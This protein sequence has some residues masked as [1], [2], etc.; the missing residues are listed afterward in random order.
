MILHSPLEG[1]SPEVRAC[2]RRAVRHHIRA[3]MPVAEA[4]VLTRYG[5]FEVHDPD[6]DRDQLQRLAWQ[7]QEF[8]PRA[9]LEPANDPASLF[10]DVTGCDAHFGGIEPLC[11]QVAEHF[12]QQGYRVRIAVA[13]TF[14]AAWGLAHHQ[15]SPDQ[16]GRRSRQTFI[17][18]ATTENLQ[19]RLAPLPVPAL[20]L[21]GEMIALLDECGLRSIGQ[22]LKL[23]RKSL[24]SRFGPELL[25][26][27]DQALG[28][29]EELLEP[30]I[31]PVPVRAE[32]GFEFPLYEPE[33]VLHVLQQLLHNVLNQLTE[34]QRE[35]QHVV[36]SWS[37]EEGDGGTFEVRLLRPTTMFDRLWDLITL[38]METLQ[39]TSGV[40][41][42]GLEAIPCTPQQLRRRT[43]FDDDET[44][45]AEFLQL[46][47][48]LSSRLGEHAVL[49]Y[50]RLAEAQPELS[51]VG[52]PWLTS[53]SPD[54]IAGTV[55]SKRP[56]PARPL[57][58]LPEPEPLRSVTQTSSGKLLRFRW[59]EQ[60]H[61]VEQSYGPERIVTGW[62]RKA[63]TRRDYYRI[64]TTRGAR[65]WL[66][67]KMETSQW[68]LQ[69]AYE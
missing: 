48:R 19:A 67:R 1:R 12:T 60:E 69:G 25:L 44:D 22:L 23:P 33:E 29:A 35:T 15:R 14:G 37:L 32:K 50:R 57:R 42:L 52:E 40:M 20:R 16:P 41:Q 62:W 49:R 27:L 28:H 8:T 10:L 55:H 63:M 5:W 13:P 58:L 54:A 68:Y 31:P 64:E 61:T 56:V 51:C 38:R 39:L 18:M 45:E 36:I 47:E 26:R 66:F 65:F 59:Q 7:C 11:R 3:G 53:A 46:I 24:P 4:R 17:T 34:R 6:S 21:P 43:L 2:C 30:D 9:G